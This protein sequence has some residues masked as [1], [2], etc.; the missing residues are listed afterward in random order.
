VVVVGYGGAGAV[1]A[2]EAADAGADVLLVEKMEHFGGLTMLCSGYMRVATDAAGAAAYL[3]W[4]NGGRTDRKLVDAL[5]RGMTEVPAYL[6]KLGRLVN[7]KLHLSVGEDQAAYETADLY[8][9][10]P[11]REAL[12]WVGIQDVPGFGGY[13]WVHFGGRGQ[14]LMRTLEANVEARAINVWLGSSV[15]R[16]I[17]E[18]GEVTG[19]VVERA[20]RTEEVRA[21]GGVI[22]ACGG[23]EFDRQLLQD[24]MESP[25]VYPMGHP[26]NT[27]DGIRLA[28]QAGA[29]LWHMWHFHGSYGFKRPEMPVAIRNHLGGSRRAERKLAWILVDQNGRRFTNELHPA[30]QDTAWRHLVEL[31]PETGTFDRIPA[32]MVFDDTGRKLGPIGKPV[33]AVADHYYDWSADNS[34][35]IDQGWILSAPT[36]EELATKAGLPKA[37]FVSTVDCWNAAVA[38]GRDAEYARPPKTLVPVAT[39]PFYAVQVWPVCSNTQGGPKHDEHQRVLDAFDRPIPGLY[40]VGELGSFFGHIYL[41]GGNLT[42]G[43]VGGR[44]AGGRAAAK[45]LDRTCQRSCSSS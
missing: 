10:W 22:L 2:I 37:A 39:P 38:S 19:I 12:G 23:F 26:G 24:Y 14:L 8:P 42:E 7:A 15:R 4:T 44:I 11:G 34:R 16:P 5:A 29:A 6:E 17:V 25:V 36:L 1:A 33:A 43:V 27:G 32:W 41:L 28:Q 21:R 3:D 40:A 13:P 35:E 31:N 45:H 20:G 9:D 30:P 18:A